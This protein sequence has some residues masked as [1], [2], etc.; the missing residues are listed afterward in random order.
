LGHAESVSFMT[1]QMQKMKRE[2]SGL[3][4]SW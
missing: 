1:H 3:S 2:D 4:K